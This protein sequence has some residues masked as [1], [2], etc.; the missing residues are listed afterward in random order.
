MS[1]GDV[2]LVTE[3]SPSA[4]NAVEEREAPDGYV[5]VPVTTGVSDND[6]IAITSGLAEGDTVAYLPAS[7]GG[8]SM[9]MPGGPGSPGGAPPGGGGPQ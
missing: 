4:V 7:G 5:Y 3:D 1:R 9:M 2:V 6:Y 8:D